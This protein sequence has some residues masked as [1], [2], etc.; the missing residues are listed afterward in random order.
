MCILLEKSLSEAFNQT[1]QEY[2]KSNQFSMEKKINSNTKE[3]SVND[4][5]VAILERRITKQKE[6]QRRR[7]DLRRLRR[8]GQ[9][10]NSNDIPILV[11]EP[12]R[13][14][15]S[16]SGG[17]INKK[18]EDTHN[19]YVDENIAYDVSKSNIFN[20]SRQ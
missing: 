13:A 7:E 17:Y 12:K 3:I 20:I 19:T 15:T 6:Y 4:S 14:N 8:Q 18:V 10:S 2:H 1:Q 9:Q 16:I 11:L 5:Q